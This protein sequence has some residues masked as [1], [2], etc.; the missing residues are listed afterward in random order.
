MTEQHASCLFP[1]LD[2]TAKDQPSLIP[3]PIGFS[4]L[5]DDQDSKYAL[6]AAAW[7]LVLQQY[8]N[9]EV[10]AFTIHESR[11]GY[12]VMVKIVINLDEPVRLLLETASRQTIFSSH[13]GYVN[14]GLVFSPCYDYANETL[15]SMVGRRTIF[16]ESRLTNR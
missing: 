16:Q 8:L 5:P 2:E 1:S 10:V 6:V 4:C 3:I 15:Q 11:L 14:N 9:L 7:S 13:P 12:T